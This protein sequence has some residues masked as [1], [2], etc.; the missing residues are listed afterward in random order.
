MRKAAAVLTSA[1]FASAAWPV[2]KMERKGVLAG[3]PSPAG[4]TVEKVK[5]LGDNEW[6]NLGSPAPDP[7]WGTA[8]GRSWG[9]KMPYAPDLGG[10]FLN[11]T[12]VHGALWPDG[13]YTDDV[14][15][16][17]LNAHRWICIYPGTDS[18]TF[19]ERIKSGELKANDNGQLVDKDGQPVP[20]CSIPHHSYQCHTYD[21]DQRKYVVGWGHRG[22]GGDQYTNQ[23]DWHKEGMKLLAEQMR[24]KTHRVV[25]TP[26][27]F[28]TVTGKWERY[29]ARADNERLK[30]RDGWG[31][32]VVFEYV[33]TR[34]ALWAFDG[35]AGTLQ[36]GDVATRQWRNVTIKGPIPKG[37][38]FGACYDS[39]R[40]R[41]YVAGGSYRE[42]WGKDEGYLYV[43][44]VKTNTWSN[45]PNKGA[46]APNYAAST[47][48]M[49]YDSVNDA[50]VAIVYW[51][52]AERAGQ[53]GV[54]VYDPAAG[55][56]ADARAADLPFGGGV[57]GHG[58]YSPEAN[59]HFLFVAGDSRDNGTMWVYRYRRPADK[60]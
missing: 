1:L 38:D 24:G 49:H 41:I 58:F 30:R 43:Y 4:P 10:A 17:D 26:F 32:G 36:I 57:A 15:F 2:E 25:D 60:E 53:T 6:L 45:A 34:K 21:A 19:V 23:M 47:T 11:G 54:Y 7:R 39:R 12:G 18:K 5:A 20:Y 51:L 56:W 52:G 3:L 31:T 40:D 42:P 35:G 27:F 37:I 59:A 33:P 29:P 9:A 16:Y 28:N 8:Y 50:V 48:A 14:W 44:D 55:R 22:L 46:P 13:R